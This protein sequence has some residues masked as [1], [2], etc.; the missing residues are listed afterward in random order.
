MRIDWRDVRSALTIAGPSYQRTLRLTHL[1]TGVT[2]ARGLLVEATDAGHLLPQ[3]GVLTTTSWYVQLA[4]E[5]AGTI[6]VG[7]GGAAWMQ[8]SGRSPT[9]DRD[10]QS[11]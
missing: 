9:G 5:P 1:P 6:V 11:R 7:P 8:V 3:R 2:E 4:N 10:S